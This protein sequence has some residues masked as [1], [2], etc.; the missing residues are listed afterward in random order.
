MDWVVLGIL[1]LLAAAAVWWVAAAPRAEVR[2]HVEGPV[3]FDPATARA[4]AAVDRSADFAA[5]LEQIPSALPSYD[6]AVPLAG[7][8]A[9]LAT[10]HDGRLWTVDLATHA[11]EPVADPGLRAWGVAATPG[12]PGR[13]YFCASGP[14][15]GRPAGA[16]AG[17]YRFD[18][19]TRAVEPVVLRVPD[20]RIG[21]ARPVV[22]AATDPAAPVLRPGGTGPTRPLGVCDSLDVSA[23][24]RRVYFSEPIFYPNAT[25]GDMLDDGVALART[26]RM[27]R[28]DL[29]TGTT[30]LVAE[31]F[32]FVNGVLCDPH[33]GQPREESVV[34]TQTS[35]CRLTRFHVAGPKAGAAEVVLDGLPGTP[36]G[37]DR[38]AAGR[39]WVSLFLERGRLLTWVHAHPWIKPLILRLPTRLLTRSGRTGVLVLTPDAGVVLYAAFHGGPGLSSVSSAIPTPAGIYLANVSLAGSDP[40]PKNIQRLRWPAELTPPPGGA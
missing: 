34:V 21:Y 10:A 23:V 32:H 30:R 14:A 17:L 7:G 28:H 35:L 4:V 6:D 19:A 18:L 31:G 33:P 29:D 27:W 15:P 8:A 2:D 9:L 24:G 11:A 12:D 36:D 39:V 38:D 22:Y 16:V 26:G 13:F 20:T 1:G 3:V 25:V 5:G 40:T 37:I